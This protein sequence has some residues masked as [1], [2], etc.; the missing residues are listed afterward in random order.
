MPNMTGGIA[1][2][3]WKC[4]AW[5]PQ[6]NHCPLQKKNDQKNKQGMDFKITRAWTFI[7]LSC[8]H[9]IAETVSSPHWKHIETEWAS[10]SRA[11]HN[12]TN[13]QRR[14][15]FGKVNGSAMEKKYLCGLSVEVEFRSSNRKKWKKKY[16]SL[17]SNKLNYVLRL[18][19]E[20][21][22]KRTILIL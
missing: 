7:V 21:I 6:E 1:T 12:E 19:V 15:W 9:E 16:S 5:T 20:P 14:L 17:E 22:C 18:A 4:F 8:F 10:N 13:K 11:R 3:A 2:K